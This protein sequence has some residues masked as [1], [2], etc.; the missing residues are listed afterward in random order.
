MNNVV[1]FRLHVPNALHVFLSVG[2][3]KG[4]LVSL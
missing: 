1:M 2:A 3:G 4:D